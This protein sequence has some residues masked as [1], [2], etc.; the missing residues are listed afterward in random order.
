MTVE[1]TP[2]N[3]ESLAALYETHIATRQEKAAVALAETGFDGLLIHSGEPFTYFADDREAAFNP[4][5]HFAHWVPAE[6]P[7]HLL[8]IA[9]N[10]T[11]LLVRVMPRDF[12]YAEP[13]PAPD[14]VRDA[15]DVV[16]VATPEE[17]WKAAGP[18][19]GFAFLGTALAEASA[20][21]IAAPAQNPETLVARLDW[22]RSYKTPY[23]IEQLA[24]ATLRAAR[25]FAAAKARFLSGGSELQIHLDYVAAVAQTEES[26]PYTTIVGLNERAATLHYHGKRGREAAPGNVLL[27]D[28]GARTRFYG[29]DITRTFTRGGDGTH[30]EFLALLEGMEK[31]QRHLADTARPGRPYLEHHLEAH[32]LIAS[33]LVETGLL[34]TTAE[35]A[36]DAGLTRPFFPH[37]LGHFLGIQVHDVSG[38]QTARTGG[39]TPPP[40]EHAA[41]R[42]TRTIEEGQVFTIEPGLYFIPML[43][44]PHRE[45]P[46]REAFDWPL[47]DALTS[48]GGIRIEDN[49]YVGK[50]ANRN[51]TREAIPN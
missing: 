11:P 40:E 26:L 50:Y 16:D 33:L 38:H 31:L 51:L 37:G 12:W 2:T 19:K 22:D 32:R 7:R 25:G 18:L 42:T 20:A 6:G 15:V 45:G 35:E 9:P 4:T 34:K 30:R 28:A 13:A 46:H 8:R 36:Y 47:I 49:V 1:T 41:L 23:E 3:G 39:R 27:I 14:F 21:A 17:A 44:S 10:K 48:H 24:E 29:C 5:P 43:L